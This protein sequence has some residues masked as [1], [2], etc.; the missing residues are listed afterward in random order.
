MSQESHMLEFFNSTEKLYMY[1]KYVLYIVK[2]M[3]PKHISAEFV[4][5]KMQLQLSHKVK[6]EH[7]WHAGLRYKVRPY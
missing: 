7:L 2:Q 1:R 4:Y 6:W 3:E 5:Q